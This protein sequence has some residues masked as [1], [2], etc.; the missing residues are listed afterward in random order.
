M[1]SIPSGYS[2]DDHDHSGSECDVN[3][4]AL[5]KAKFDNSHAYLQIHTND[6]VDPINTGPGDLNTPG[7]VR[8]NIAPHSKLKRVSPSEANRSTK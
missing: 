1:I 7:E 2:T 3:T 8:G 4:L 5:L 6:G